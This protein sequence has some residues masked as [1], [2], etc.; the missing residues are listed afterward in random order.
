[1]KFSATLRR[2]QGEVREQTTP[3]ERAVWCGYV[4]LIVVLPPLALILLFAGG[5]GSGTG[6]GLLVLTLVLYATPMSAILKARIRRR[7]ARE[8]KP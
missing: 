6:I 7:E 3:A 4:V 8:R 2:I 1:M 5:H